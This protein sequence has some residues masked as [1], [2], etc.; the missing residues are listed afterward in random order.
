MYV[1]LFKRP[2]AW[3]RPTFPLV[4]KEGAYLIVGPYGYVR[5]H[6]WCL[7]FAHI[8]NN[9]LLKEFWQYNAVG[10]SN[11]PPSFLNS[12]QDFFET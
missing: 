5:L 4:A 10:H 7:T 3:S 8:N 9:K 12:A 6:F 2:S 11:I 1:C